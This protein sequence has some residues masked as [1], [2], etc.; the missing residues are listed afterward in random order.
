MLCGW[1]F[2]SS[3]FFYFCGHVCKSQLCL[4]L[5]G[6]KAKQDLPTVSRGWGN[7]TFTSF[8]AWRPSWLWPGL[9]WGI[10]MQTKWRW[11][12]RGLCE[13][14]SGL[15]VPLCCWSLSMRTPGLS[16]A[17]LVHGYSYRDLYRGNRGL[18]LHHILVTSVLV[19]LILQFP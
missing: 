12:S 2:S 1:F 7:S 16:W 17:I 11:S 15:L 10:E 8:L 9:A 18:L 5:G 13:A 3:F 6:V 19:F 4:D 14:C